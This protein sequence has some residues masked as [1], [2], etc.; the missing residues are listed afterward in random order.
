MRYD[1][2]NVY[3]YTHKYKYIVKSLGVKTHTQKS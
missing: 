1:F 2:L 3:T